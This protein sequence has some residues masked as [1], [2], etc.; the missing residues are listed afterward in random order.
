MYNNVDL[1]NEGQ[2]T[3]S[4]ALT[5]FGGKAGGNASNLRMSAEIISL[6]QK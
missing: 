2:K 6:A 3:S 4:Y 5:S 1:R